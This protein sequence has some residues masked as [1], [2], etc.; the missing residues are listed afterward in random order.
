M[1]GPEQLNIEQRGLISAPHYMSHVLP[2]ALKKGKSDL[3]TYFVHF[4]LREFQRP[5]CNQFG[6][7]KKFLP[8]VFAVV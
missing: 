2:L 8:S 4:S 1:E 5:T 3:V 6:W 7:R